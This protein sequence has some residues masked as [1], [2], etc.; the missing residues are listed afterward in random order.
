MRIIDE[1]NL[2]KLAHH[3][4]L[5]NEKTMLTFKY[6]IV[7]TRLKIMLELCYFCA[8]CHMN[9]NIFSNKNLSTNDKKI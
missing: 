2:T 8:A 5:F 4:I 6:Y 3:R 1:I 7:I 9:I